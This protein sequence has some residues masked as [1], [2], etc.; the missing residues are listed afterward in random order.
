MTF[1]EKLQFFWERNKRVII[2]TACCLLA[3]VMVGVVAVK[4]SDNAGNK[5]VNTSSNMQVRF[6]M[7]VE[8]GVVI[9]DFSNTA[10]K[11]NATLKQWEAHKA[12]DIKGADNAKVFAA[13]DG[14]V[15][16]VENN[17]LSGTVVTIKHA[18]NLQTVYASMSENVLVK[19]GDTVTAGQQIGT[20]SVSAKSEANDGA[21]LH[22]E[23]LLNNVKVDPN[24]YLENT[25]K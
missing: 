20:V 11:Y 9:K 4:T 23:V 14:E 21:H 7:P 6:V 24:L 15:V 12:V 8:N 25:N 17:Y 22:F 5:T 10:L 3:F 2:G 16:S 13:Y 18:G 19:A 1:K